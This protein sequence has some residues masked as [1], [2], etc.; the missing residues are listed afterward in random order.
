MNILHFIEFCWI[1][2]RELE[3]Y[4]IKIKDAN[5]N[6]SFISYNQASSSKLYYHDCEIMF[7]VILYNLCE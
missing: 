1:S 4:V 3:F 5:N 6:K 2:K 7:A